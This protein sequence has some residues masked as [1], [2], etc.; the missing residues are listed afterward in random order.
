MSRRR[1][2]SW[3]RRKARLRRRELFRTH[4]RRL[5]G[6][7]AAI[8]A[9][10]TA[11]VTVAALLIG[12]WMAWFIAGAVYSALIILWAT[13]FDLLD[14]VGRHLRQGADGE[15]FTA[16]QLR[17]CARH[18]WR[19]THNLVLEH[20]DIDHIAIGPGGVV[21]IETKCPDADW[22]WLHR[23]GIAR[24]WARQARSSALRAK[25]LV[26]QHAGL[27]LEARPILVVWTRGLA[28]AGH[29]EVDGVRVIHGSD[30]TELLDELPRVLDA[31]QV[32]RI[33]HALEPV[34]RQLDAHW[35][36]RNSA[37]AGI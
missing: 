25:A 17:R 10:A 28:D 36:T 21:A 14:P 24:R 9:I 7:L 11:A 5:L 33:H 2:G 3:A 12:A 1:A 22:Q 26:R 30:L 37:L 32:D 19:A 31:D 8:T 29:V 23:H 6:L 34:A 20:G 18:G 16:E 4:R 15:S 13:M 27:R 35:R